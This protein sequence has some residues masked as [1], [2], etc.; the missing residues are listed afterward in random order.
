MSFWK[1]LMTF[2]IVYTF[3]NL[4]YLKSD[5]FQYNFF[6][7]NEFVWSSLIKFSVEILIFAILLF[8][9]YNLIEF[10]QKWW[11]EQK[12]SNAQKERTEEK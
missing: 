5:F 3:A 4:T 12:Y 6:Y 9:V 7:N 1:F 10:L 11:M 8:A 2:L